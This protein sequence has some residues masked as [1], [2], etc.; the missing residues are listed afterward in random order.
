[1]LR[2]A[3]L[4]AVTMAVLARL[5][6][7]PAIAQATPQE[8]PVRSFYFDLLGHTEFWIDLAPPPKPGDQVSPVT[9][10]FTVRFK[11]KVVREPE[12]P[13][14]LLI[15]R[16]Q[17]NALYNPL[18]LRQPA[19]ILEADGEP[20]WDPQLPVNFYYAGGSLTEGGAGFADTVD[21]SVP[22]E[23]LHQI[24]SATKVTGNA[25]GFPFELT[26]AQLVAV[27]ALAARVFP[28]GPR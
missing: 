17:A 9:L 26:G 2:M 6:T 19:L 11:G 18:V 15:V 5:A 28:A 23:T 16:A 12:A 8:N 22:A 10:N 7:T 20:V 4:T 13:P 21:V 1:M 3:L 24:A 25:L 14:Y 27:R